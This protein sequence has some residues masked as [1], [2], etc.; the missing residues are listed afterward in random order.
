MRKLISILIVMLLANV[1]F[2][3][4]VY[5]ESFEY[6]DNASM[7]AEWTGLFGGVRDL[8]TTIASDGA[9]SGQTYGGSG[10]RDYLPGII[11]L[12]LGGTISFDWYV[13]TANGILPYNFEMHFGNVGFGGS[14]YAPGFTGGNY[15]LNFYQGAPNPDTPLGLTLGEGWNN[16]VI[17]V[18]ADGTMDF[19]VNAATSGFTIAPGYWNGFGAISTFDWTTTATGTRGIIDNIVVDAIPEPMTI[20]LLG[21]GGLLL[22]RRKR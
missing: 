15:A 16:V 12:P 19:E 5:Q 3:A 7:Q 11:D 2:G 4:I 6:A 22:R 21:F 1:S 10:M 20:C 9:K 14:L 8:N 17:S 13:D 18:A